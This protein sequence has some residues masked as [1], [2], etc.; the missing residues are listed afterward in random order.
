MGA[1]E[2]DPLLDVFTV[3]EHL[4]RIHLLHH[5]GLV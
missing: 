4:S 1:F 2:R 5:A 3:P